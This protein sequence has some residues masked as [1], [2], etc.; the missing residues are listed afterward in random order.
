MSVPP[1]LPAVV[2]R[3]TISGRSTVVVAVTGAATGDEMIRRAARRAQRSRCPLTGVH[4]ARAEGRAEADPGLERHRRLLGELGGTYHEVI[5][6]DVADALVRFAHAEG[7]TEL[8]LG[9]P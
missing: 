6:D 5:S 3:S 8:V 7:A 1:T 2:R 9:P 4:V